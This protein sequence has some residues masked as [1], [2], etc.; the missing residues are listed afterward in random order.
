MRSLIQMPSLQHVDAST[1]LEEEVAMSKDLKK[2][3]LDAIDRLLW[4][5][6]S[7]RALAAAKPEGASIVLTVFCSALVHA[8]LAT[9]ASL[10]LQIR[11]ERKP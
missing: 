7:K 10:W 8:F 2:A 4:G 3:K 9:K 1:L 6:K 5:T 11:T